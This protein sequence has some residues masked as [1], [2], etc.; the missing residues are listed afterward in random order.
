MRPAAAAWE[1]HY[2]R[3]LEERGFERGEAC[4]VA[5]FHAELDIACAVHGDDFTFCGLREDL[6]V[7]QGWLKEAF[8]IEVRGML[9]ESDFEDKEAVILG[10]KVRWGRKGIEYEAD[11]K[12]R[13]K[14]L[15]Y[16]GFDDSSRTL[17]N[18]GDKNKR[19]DAKNRANLRKNQTR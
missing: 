3:V 8:E 18:N 5:F 13:Q 9:G 7:V 11:L 15:E 6:L 19:G 10:R 12:H 16:F 4:G 17:N 2:A 14:L 1:N